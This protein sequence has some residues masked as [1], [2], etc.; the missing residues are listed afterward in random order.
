[1]SK[2][3]NSKAV[4]SQAKAPEVVSMEAM[5]FVPTMLRSPRTNKSATKEKKKKSQPIP[6]RKSM[7][8]NLEVQQKERKDKAKQPEELVDLEAE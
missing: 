8:K 6:M 1:M 2:P 5:P 7:R 3:I 4:V